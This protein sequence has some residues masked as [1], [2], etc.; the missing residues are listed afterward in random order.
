M[1]I[2]AV[3][4]IQILLSAKLSA[5]AN[6]MWLTSHAKVPEIN[7]SLHVLY[8]TP[9]NIQVVEPSTA[10]LFTRHDTMKAADDINNKDIQEAR[11]ARV[12][13]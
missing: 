1:L 10:V 5:S 4:E 6:P 3:K 13:W 9:Y 8:V 7:R 2:T 12:H 11:N